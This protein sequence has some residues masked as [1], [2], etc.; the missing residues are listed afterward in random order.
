M[1]HRD[2]AH[3][4]AERREGTSDEAAHRALVLP[5]VLLRD[6]RELFRQA[7][8]RRVLLA[9]QRRDVL[10]LAQALWEQM[11]SGRAPAALQPVNS[12]PAERADEPPR[13]ERRQASPRQERQAAVQLEMQ[14]R[15][16]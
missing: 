16:A 10:I 3:L 8:A 5:A 11:A 15:W 12:A 9:Q 4:D 6:A 2:E 1:D 7:E 14:A 13:V